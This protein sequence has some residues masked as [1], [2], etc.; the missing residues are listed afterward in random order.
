MQLGLQQS[1]ESNKFMKNK[2]RGLLWVA[3]G[4]LSGALFATSF[5][6]V[7]VERKSS[8]PLEDIRLFSDV[9]GAARSNYVDPVTDQKLMK[10]A[11]K[12]MLRGLDPHSDFLDEEAY[13]ELQEG[14]HG[15]FGGLGIEV[16]SDPLGVKVVSPIDD[17]PAAKAGVR[18]GDII[19][20]IDGKLIKNKSLNDSVKKMRGKPDTEIELTISR[21]GEAEPIVLKLKRAMIKVRSVKSKELPDGIGYIRIS[22]FQEKTTPDIVKAL[23]GLEKSGHLKNG[24]VLDLRNDPGG[25]LNA[26]IGV[27]AAFLPKDSLVVSTK[28][29]E[30]T[31]NFK[32]LARLQDYEVSGDD[33][34]IDTLPERVKTVPVVV[35][36]NGASASASEIVAGALQDHKRATIMGLRSFGKGSVQTVIPLRY[37][38]KKVAIKITT[39]RYYTPNGRSIQAKGIKP[40]IEVKDTADGNFIDVDIREA[41]LENHLEVPEQGDEEK[42]KADKSESEK[43]PSVKP[44]ADKGS[45]EK[46]S[47]KDSS[48]KPSSEKTAEKAASEKASSTKASEEKKPADSSVAD[49]KASDGKAAATSDKKP[50]AAE[51][52]KKSEDAPAAAKEEKKKPKFYKY[53]DPDDYQLNEAVKYLLKK[54]GIDKTPDD[55][56]KIIE[57]ESGIKMKIEPIK[58]EAPKPEAQNAAPEAEKA[59]KDEK[60]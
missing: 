45:A 32:Y 55:K 36:V 3:A 7:A 27:S 22:Q 4:M 43:D 11:V 26:A 42:D 49:K 29:Q 51:S 24:L 57:L 23:E 47:S 52:D 56:P 5:P 10:E 20:K 37:A 53:G 6:G 34:K 58:E 13:K 2:T 16:T 21:K 8:L 41:D 39:A 31:N 38:G 60:K 25:L 9:Y 12:G 44:D 1:V 18:P 28:G 30:G 54:A 35:L 19:F 40:D 50:D 33:P 15:E 46:P 59:G 17:T 14:T 48:V